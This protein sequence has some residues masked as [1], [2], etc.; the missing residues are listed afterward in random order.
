LT[1]DPPSTVFRY[2]NAAFTAAERVVARAL[3][4]PKDEIAAE[5]EKRFRAPLGASSW[6]VYH[7]DRLFTPD[8]IENPGPKLAI[9]STLRDLAKWGQ[10]W[11]D[12]GQASGR[13]LIPESWV[14]RAI[15]PANPGIPGPPY[16]YNWFL[17]TGRLLW[18]DAPP[19]SFGHAGFGT[20][21][22]SERESRCYLWIC[23]SLAVVAAMVTDVTVGFANDFLDIP[24]GLTAEWAGRVA[25][26]VPG[27]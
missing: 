14:R 15:Q 18:P 7:F 25:A 24:N 4:L 5:V 22:P 21:K 27:S 1:C 19:D 23:P 6:R 26:A 12:G 10:L 17:N 20:F 16:G 3:R 8:N 9:N 13:Q 11:L 2:N